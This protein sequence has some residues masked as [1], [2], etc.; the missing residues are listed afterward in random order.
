[1]LAASLFPL[2]TSL[3]C[4]YKKTRSTTS[5]SRRITKNEKVD[6]SRTKAKARQKEKSLISST[7]INQKE[8]ESKRTHKEKH[9]HAA[10]MIK[11][12]FIF[13]PSFIYLLCI[14]ERILTISKDAQL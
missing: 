9:A 8:R 14:P 7:S 10:W 13:F 3:S 4:F 2:R 1:M 12:F 11:E 5:P 6:N